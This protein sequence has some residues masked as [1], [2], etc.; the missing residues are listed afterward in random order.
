[1]TASFPT[2]VKSFTT[3]VD[4]VN[5]CMAVDV[6][7]IQEEVVAI[8]TALGAPMEGWQPAIGSWTYAS[9]STITVPTNATLTYQR[10]MKLRWKQGAGY[11]YGVI[12]TVAATLITI[13]VSTSYTVANSAITDVYYSMAAIPFG[14]PSFLA[15]TPAVTY[16]GGTTDP[17]SNTASGKFSVNGGVISYFVTSTLVR[18]TGNRTATIFSVPLDVGGT[19][20]AGSGADDITAAGLT[21]ANLVYIVNGTLVYS[22]TMANNGTY[23]A[24][25]WAYI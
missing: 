4:N 18:G 13:V 12:H 22:R 16:A 2:S 20:L 10:G 21:A 1:M 8:E 5:D 6:N 7:G 14:F 11:K 25:A 23:Y 15:F 17:T 19:L 24:S 9:A 3:K